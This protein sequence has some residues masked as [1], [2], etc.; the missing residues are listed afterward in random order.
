[1]G[2]VALAWYIS[3]LSAPLALLTSAITW[4]PPGPGLM[5]LALP[6]VFA[7]ARSSPPGWPSPWGT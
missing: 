1:M 6:V 7:A 3:G 2:V 4:D 5:A